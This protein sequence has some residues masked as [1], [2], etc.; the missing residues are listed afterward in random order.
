MNPLHLFAIAL[1]ILMFVGLIF[2]ALVRQLA[3]R[4]WASILEAIRG[5]LFWGVIWIL[6]SIWA[7]L[8][9]ATTLAKLT[10]PELIGIG[11]PWFPFLQVFQLTTPYVMAFILMIFAA[12]GGFLVATHFDIIL[13]LIGL[14]NQWGNLSPSERTVFVQNLISS[15]IFIAAGLVMVYADSCVFALRWAMD[16][17]EVES[18]FLGVS[19]IA[20][21]IRWGYFLGF[22][23][24]SWIVHRKYRQF[25]IAARIEEPEVIE[26]I[27][28]E[29][30]IQESPFPISQQAQPSV[31][32][33]QDGAAISRG[34][35]Q[36]FASSSH[37]FEQPNQTFGNDEE[38]QRPSFV[39]FEAVPVGSG[40]FD[41]DEEV[42][43]EHLNP[44]GNRRR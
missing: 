17:G 41:S 4:R 33:R 23:V 36:F 16:V 18:E 24:L 25:L 2:L 12:A 9:Q 38:K 42:L 29:Q 21:L 8:L 26:V 35:Q 30:H 39:E 22:V 34:A 44:F 6:F 19:F 3:G 28:E 15:I 11:E 27:P 13:G 10:R 20:D 37:Q 32:I 7:Y 43:P 1:V 31:P 5:L 40:N 14:S